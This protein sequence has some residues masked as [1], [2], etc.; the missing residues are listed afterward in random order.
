MPGM[1]VEQKLAA[2][3]AAD[4]VGG[5]RLMGPG[6]PGVPAGLKALPG[7]LTWKCAWA[8]TLILGLVPAAAAQQPRYSSDWDKKGSEAQS[9][10]PADEKLQR[11][12]DELNALIDDAERA[13]AADPRFLSD[14]RDLARRYAWPWTVRIV[15]DDFSDGDVSRNPAWSVWGADLRVHRRRGVTMRVAA[16]A[17]TEPP[18]P[19]D[20]KSD[21][22]LPG[23]VFKTLLGQLARPEQRSG[24]TQ[25]PA[26]P[27]PET[28]SGMKLAAAVP[29]AFAIPLNLQSATQGTGRFEVGVTQ[30]NANSGY[31]LAYNTG[32]RPAL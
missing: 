15:S 1:R 10:D 21:A 7:R 26:T 28:E 30:G 22:D 29:N 4:V 32:G 20:Q 27:E 31:R 24:E 16:P 19:V 14:L 12:T 3:P 8:M 11:L 9:I 13:R 6:E 2:I 23:A 5:L 17:Q 18:K 25:S